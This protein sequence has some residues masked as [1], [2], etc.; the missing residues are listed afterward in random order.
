M[1]TAS[2][3][4]AVALFDSTSFNVGITSHYFDSV[5][6]QNLP[7]CAAVGEVID[8]GISNAN[9]TI[10]ILV[11]V[12]KGATKD[13][14]GMVVADWGKG[15]SKVKMPKNL[16]FGNGHTDEGPLCI[17]GVGLNNFLLVATR[18]KYPWFIASKEPGEDTYHRV[19][20]PFATTMT[21][22][23]QKEIPMESIVMRDQYKALGAPS[24]IVYVEM[25]K[26]TASTMLTKNGN[27][28][29]SKVTSLNV[30]RVA[31]A[32]HLG[33]MYRNYL[34]PD[35]T[36]IAPARILIPDYR[37]ADGKTCD[38]LVKP[39]FQVYRNKPTTENFAVEYNEHEIPVKVI[40]GLLDYE[41][42]KGVVTGGYD[43]KHFYQNNMHTQGVDIQLG[44]RVIATAQF[45]T[46]WEKARH[47][48]FNAFTGVVSIDITGLP[49][50]F[51]NTLANKSNIDLSDKGWSMIF[52][53]I[54]EKVNPLESEPFSLENYVKKFSEQLAA[55]T[56]NKVERQFTLYANRTRI[57]VLEY[58]DET[59]CRI[60]DFTKGTANLESLTELRTHWDGMVTQGVQ[61]VSAVMYCGKRGPML[62]HTCEDWNTKGQSM[63]DKDL[64]LAFNKANGDVAK[65]PHYNFD[66][67]I[68]A[69]IP[70]DN[71]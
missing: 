36:G 4:K 14:I 62:M 51:L 7:M 21:M 45:D 47:P 59:H 8:N 40:Y 28:A 60:Y 68:D 35:A 41:A 13:T 64:L 53:V 26:A 63:D 22:T 12:M 20:G 15:M 32:E 71:R 27:C 49:R 61:P 18:N 31:L 6:R 5:S 48:S 37:M 29:E 19:E 11:A 23:E 39:I 38:V 55:S 56:G 57:D 17:H 2:F 30:L 65:M 44:D 42:T 33:V 50:G 52:G 43:L 1:K 3:N 70:S 25:D 67:V 9:G 24:T 16:Q 34:A 69:N 66:V 46:I 58:L 10:N 54:A